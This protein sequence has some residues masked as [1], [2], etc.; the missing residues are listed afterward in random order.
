[1]VS[2]CYASSFFGGEGSQFIYPA[3]N[4]DYF[5]TLFLEKGDLT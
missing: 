1:M 2:F 3:A 5:R 4:M